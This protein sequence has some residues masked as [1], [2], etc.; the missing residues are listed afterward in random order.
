[1]RFAL[2]FYPFNYKVHEENIRIVQK[3]FGVFPPL[4]E[5]WVAAIAEKH[6]HQCIIVDARTLML[7]KAEVVDILKL[8]RPDIVGFRV[9]TYMFP[10]MLEWARHIKRSLN[11]PILIGG[12]NLR[13]YPKES[14]AH[15]EIDFGCVNSALYTVPR[16]LEELESGRRGFD[17][18]PGLVYKKNGEIIQTPPHDPPERF[19][20]YPNPARHL[21]PNELYAEFPTT[22]RNFSLMV[23]SKG[24]PM[25]CVFCEAGGT[26]YDPRSPE[27][28]V[29]EMEECVRDYN[30]HEIDIFDYEFPMIRKRTMA[31]CREIQ[32][33]KLDVVWCCR[34]RVDTVDEELLR[35]MKKAG[36]HR[37][38]F[39]I[40]SVHQKVLNEVRKGITPDQVRKTIRICKELD[41]MALGF[42][43]IG[44]PGESEK[45]IYE[46]VEFAKELDLDYAQFSKLLAKPWS[47][48]WKEMVART[49]S[50]Y[51]REWVLGKETDRPLARHWTKLSNET[52]DRIARNCY[53][54][55]AL[56]P[57]Y[58]FRETMKCGSLFEWK[59]KAAALFD[60]LFSQEGV[61]TGD[62]GFRIYNAAPLEDRRAAMERLWGPNFKFLSLP[63]IPKPPPPPIL[64]YGTGESGPLKRRLK[65]FWFGR[66]APAATPSPA[67]AAYPQSQRPPGEA[68]G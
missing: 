5:M 32:R 19:D 20:D 30:I 66:H 67:P 34:S 37:I 28:V 41:I 57:G 17:E 15:P 10:D 38:Y 56:R 40:E 11:V 52:I 45:M 23:T 64:S 43:L 47:G 8:F 2:V 35:E 48:Y 39:G 44:N 12:Y 21:V 26:A 49:G 36:C 59:R 16:L 63:R 65:V 58:L 24:C 7:S 46:T 55:F 18:V 9:T 14:L 13:V 29:D 61:S 53:W 68:A 22:R 6:G 27:K 1:M 60:M 33:R 4:N 42:F 50:D 51:W 25:R 31:I 62:P 3:Y 54:R